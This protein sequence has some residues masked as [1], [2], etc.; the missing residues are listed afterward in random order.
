LISR[1]PLYHA[2]NITKPL[3]VTHGA[4]D[5]NVPRTESDSL[6]KEMQRCQK[7]V[8]YLVYAEEGHDYQ[9]PATYISLFAV[10]ERFFS[11]HLGGR[12]EPFGKD[13]ADPGLEIVAGADLIPGLTEAAA[14]K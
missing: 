2:T 10:A 13:L 1:S 7:P 8:T 5:T 6:V 4:K 12:Y 14:A 11:E 9:S 3:L